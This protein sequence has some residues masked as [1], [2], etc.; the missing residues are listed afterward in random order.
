M[1]KNDCRS[2]RQESKHASGRVGALV[3]LSGVSCDTQGNRKKIPNHIAMTPPDDDNNNSHHHY[4]CH[5]HQCRRSWCVLR[6]RLLLR[7]L[8]LLPTDGPVTTATTTT[9]QHMNF[10]SGGSLRQNEHTHHT[11]VLENLT[12]RKARVH[13]ARLPTNQ[14]PNLIPHT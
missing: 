2:P 9:T 8:P 13:A 4:Y 7:I 10:T 1:T 5:R 12:P 3:C 14:F 11:P 6:Q